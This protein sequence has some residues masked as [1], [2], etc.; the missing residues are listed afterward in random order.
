LNRVWDFEHKQVQMN[1]TVT[2]AMDGDQEVPSNHFTAIKNFDKKMLTIV[3]NKLRL[4]PKGNKKDIIDRIENYFDNDSWL[5]E[6]KTDDFKTKVPEGVAR[7]HHGN[8]LDLQYY[9]WR[10]FRVTENYD[11][12]CV[13]LQRQDSPPHPFE[14]MI[15]GKL[16]EEYCDGK[17]P[18][19]LIKEQLQN[20]RFEFIHIPVNLPSNGIENTSFRFESIDLTPNDKFQVRKRLD[21]NQSND[22]DLIARKSWVYLAMELIP[23]G[24]GDRAIFYGF[25]KHNLDHNRDEFEWQFQHEM[26]KGVNVDYHYFFSHWTKIDTGVKLLLNATIELDRNLNHVIF[27]CALHGKFVTSYAGMHYS[28]KFICQGCSKENGIPRVGFDMT[29]QSVFYV[30]KYKNRKKRR[31][32]AGIS[33]VKNYRDRLSKHRSTGEG[34]LTI[35]EELR[36]HSSNIYHLER[37]L[38]IELLGNAGALER[39][40]S[41]PLDFAREIGLIDHNGNIT[42]F[43]DLD[44]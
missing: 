7:Y 3:A 43:P 14:E 31:I 20:F 18:S 30:L 15:L 32:N 24:W 2:Y 34:E 1:L 16:I 22:L 5:A 36:G 39:Y 40:Q 44:K 26:E 19:D 4:S 25:S 28:R 23:K 35:I 21:N 8:R 27:E 9:L 42:L 10:K 17:I 11:F 33:N 37:Q 29:G 13:Y 12:I 6:F 38:K 41:N